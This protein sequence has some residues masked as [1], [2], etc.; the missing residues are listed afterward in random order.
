MT[1]LTVVLLLKELEFVCG[2]DGRFANLDHGLV[3][4]QPAMLQAF[5]QRETRA[6]T[7]IKRHF[8]FTCQCTCTCMYMY[9]H[10]G[11]DKCQHITYMYMYE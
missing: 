11:R 9:V 1:S 4:H 6:A 8:R 10:V 3:E 7:A 5:L 2:E